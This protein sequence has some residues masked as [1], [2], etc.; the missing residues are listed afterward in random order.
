MV[1]HTPAHNANNYPQPVGNVDL[2]F[3]SM[4]FSGPRGIK[5][6]AIQGGA[7]IPHDSRANYFNNLNLDS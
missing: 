7:L 5:L 4:R 1:I 2:S 3:E 6:L